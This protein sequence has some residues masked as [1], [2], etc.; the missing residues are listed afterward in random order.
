MNDTG[1]YRIMR[2]YRR[3]E[4]NRHGRKA[5]WILSPVRLPV[6]PLRQYKNEDYFT[7]FIRSES[8]TLGKKYTQLHGPS[9]AVLHQKVPDRLPH[10]VALV[11]AGFVDQN[12]DASLKGSAQILFDEQLQFSQFFWY[13]AFVLL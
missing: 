1:Q 2:W 4:S 12:P 8:S 11:T 6:S 9:T 13:P 7:S 5:R 3:S 10:D